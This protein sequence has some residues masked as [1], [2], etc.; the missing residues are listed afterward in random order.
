[1]EHDEQ[2]SVAEE[3]SVEN[4]TSLADEGHEDVAP[5]DD[6]EQRQFAEWLEKQP[7]E[8]RKHYLKLAQAYGFPG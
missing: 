5:L 8:R 3:S 7:P 1:M 6:E 4:G 2:H